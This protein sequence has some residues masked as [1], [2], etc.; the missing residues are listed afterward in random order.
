MVYFALKFKNSKNGAIVY[1]KDGL[2]Y[3]RI[4]NTT[5][6][7]Y[8][9]TLDEAIDELDKALSGIFDLGDKNK[10]KTFIRKDTLLEKIEFIYGLLISHLINKIPKQNSNKINNIGNHMGVLHA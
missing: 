3:I 9:K 8:G 7:V 5:I 2:Y 10:I 6:M 4:T 1:K